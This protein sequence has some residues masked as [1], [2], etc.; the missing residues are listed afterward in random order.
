MR[1]PRQLPMVPGPGGGA[2]AGAGLGKSLV[3]QRSL[4][5]DFSDSYLR[6][7]YASKFTSYLRNTIAATLRLAQ[8]IQLAS[9]VYLSHCTVLLAMINYQGLS[10]ISFREAR[11]LGLGTYILT[12]VLIRPT[13]TWTLSPI[14]INVC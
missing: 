2:G 8:T 14:L 7:T 5:E 11:H 4:P 3:N 9:D 12:L 6:E 13:W 1:Q 10:F